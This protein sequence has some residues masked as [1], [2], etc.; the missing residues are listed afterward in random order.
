[1]IASASPAPMAGRAMGRATRQKACQGRQ[2]KHPRRLH[3]AAPLGEE[4]GAREQ[5]DVGVEDQHQHG[6]HAA[7]GAHARQPQAA[8]EPLAQQRLHRA[9]EIQQADE[10][11]RQHVGRDRERQHQRPVQPAPAGEF[12]EAGEPGKADAEHGHAHPY[13]GHQHQGIAQQARHLGFP[14]V[15]PDFAVDF[16]PAQQQ[17]ADGQQNQGGDDKGDGGPA[18]GAHALRY[19]RRSAGVRRKCHR[20]TDGNFP[21]WYRIRLILMRQG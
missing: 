5:I 17:D 10:D 21:H 1:M 18:V 11:E 15:R 9:G 13:T 14:Q 19:S 7:G 2:A 3:Q 16:R 4:G 20:R 6:D 12:A 8:A